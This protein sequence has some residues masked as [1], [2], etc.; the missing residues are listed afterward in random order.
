MSIT[1]SI[2]EAE[3]QEYIK[4]VYKKAFSWKKSWIYLVVILVVIGFNVY[5]WSSNDTSTA[6]ELPKDGEVSTH[7]FG[8]LWSWL[9]FI[10]ILT[11]LWIFIFRRLRGTAML[12]KEDRNLI[13]GERT[14]IFDTDKVQVKAATAETT[15]QWNALKKW[16]QT[17]HLYL[18]YISSNAAIIVPKRAFETALAAQEFEILLKTNI[19]NL[20]N[21]IGRA[22]C[23]ERV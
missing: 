7:L 8:S 4:N 5:N 9:F 23:R 3:F 20:T 16:D 1:Y 17:A 14:M 2:T 11:A 22:S 21:E 6:D 12:K 19:E 13:L 15:Y 10:G 18:L